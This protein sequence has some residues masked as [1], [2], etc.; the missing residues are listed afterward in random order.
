M[1]RKRW[2]SRGRC[3]LK[4]DPHLVI[5]EVPLSFGDDQEVLCGKIVHHAQQVTMWDALQ[6]GVTRKLRQLLEG[7]RCCRK[8]LDALESGTGGLRYVY[9]IVPAELLKE[10][11]AA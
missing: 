11:E 5:S 2:T 3:S 10:S 8:C 4:S 6:F 7:Q 9:G 1:G